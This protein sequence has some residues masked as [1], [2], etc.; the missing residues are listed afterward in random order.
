MAA[1]FKINFLLLFRNHLL[2]YAGIVYGIMGIW[3]YGDSDLFKW[4]RQENN[5]AAV[6]QTS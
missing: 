2:Y 5:I 6:G 3:E 1:I 4:W